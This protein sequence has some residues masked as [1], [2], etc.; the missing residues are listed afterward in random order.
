MRVMFMLVNV[1]GDN[2]RYEVEE[3]PLPVLVEFY[4]SWCGKCAMMEDVV[5]EFAADNEGR[6]KVCLVDSDSEESLAEELGVE[7]C[8]HL[9]HSAPERRK[10]SLWEPSRGRLWII[11]SGDRRPYLQFGA[12]DGSGRCFQRENV[13]IRVIIWK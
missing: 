8:P 1:T 10:E 12:E 4:A 7:R 2:F 9:W 5:A 11:S 3:S 6:V 13:R